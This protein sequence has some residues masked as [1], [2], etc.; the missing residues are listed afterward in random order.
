MENREILSVLID[1]FKEVFDD[2]ELVLTR[3]TTA[4]DIEEWDSLNQIKLIVESERA[5]NIRLKSRDI[6]ILE[7]IGEM[8]DHLS[9][10]IN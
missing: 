8:V 9:K 1:V 2:E 5:F 3:E 4:N 7:N 10:V 6:N